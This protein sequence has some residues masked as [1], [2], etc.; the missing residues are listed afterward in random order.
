[1]CPDCGNG[2][3]RGDERS[4]LCTCGNV[5]TRLKSGGIDF[6]RDKALPSF[7][8]N[9]EDALHNPVLELELSGIENR[10]RDFFLPLMER[11]ARISGKKL[12]DLKVLDC[13]CGNGLLVDIMNKYGMDAW[14]V[15]AGRSRHIQWC[16][17]L[18][19]AT[20]VSANAI[21]IPFMDRTFD[22]VISSGLIE[23][24]GIHEEEINGYRSY[25][26]ADCDNQRRQ[27]AGELARILKPDGFILLD[28]PNGA[29]PADFWHGGQP[30]SIRWHPVRGDM[31]PRFDE[32]ARYFKMADHALKY[33]SLSPRRRLGFKVVG[34]LWY[35]RLFTPIMKIWL[36]IIDMRCLSFLARSFLNPYM[37]TVFTRR[38]DAY[39]W[40]YPRH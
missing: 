3:E 23:H 22:A 12:N 14:G 18:S 40:I 8:M 7:S 31:L 37:V 11:Y 10:F 17:R 5:Y 4:I 1:M 32:I 38:P 26:L 9:E 36:K 15:D 30:G 13:G 29:F 24:I 6:L 20:L 25:R 16:R 34:T 2:L 39:A 27:F 33:F 35:G 19:G 21:K 28:H